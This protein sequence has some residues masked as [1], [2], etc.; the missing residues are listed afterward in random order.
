MILG[1]YAVVQMNRAAKHRNSAIPSV[2]QGKLEFAWTTDCALALLDKWGD[3][4]RERM[5]TV[6]YWDFAFIP[7]YSLFLFVVCSLVTG[8][9]TPT[10]NCLSGLGVILAYGQIV[11]GILDAIENIGLLQ[12]LKE[13]PALF[14]APL[15][16]SCAS[17]KWLIA[18]TGLFYFLGGMMRL[19]LANQKPSQVF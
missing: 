13:S 19:L 4:S 16:S 8:A 3:Q 14:W 9:I 18:V 12:L 2:N 7:A 11:A 10:S 1:T 15:A 17:I 6:V 5:R